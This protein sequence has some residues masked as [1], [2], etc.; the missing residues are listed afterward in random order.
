MFQTACNLK[1]M[2]ISAVL[3][4]QMHDYLSCLAYLQP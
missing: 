3:P 4:A 2:N 1:Q